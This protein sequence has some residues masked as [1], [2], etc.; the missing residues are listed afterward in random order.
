MTPDIVIT[1]RQQSITIAMELENDIGWDFQESMRQLKK[2]R[3]KFSDV[4]IIIPREYK[5]FAPLY[6]H[7]RFPVY[8]WSAKRKWKCLRCGQV[9]VNESRI[10][11]R[12]EGTKEKPCG[13]S[14]RDEFEL[15]GLKDT[16]IEQYTPADSAHACS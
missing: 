3:K 13:N 9:N 11:P 16:K 15:V 6:Y 14:S 7:E 4:R 10:P 8:L 2:Y 12:C 5:R 1:L